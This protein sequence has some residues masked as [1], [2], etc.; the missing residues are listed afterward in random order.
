MKLGISNTSLYNSKGHPITKDGIGHYTQHLIDTLSQRDDISV[1]EISFRGFYKKLATSCALHPHYHQLC[2]KETNHKHLKNIDLLHITDHR[3]PITRVRIPLIA[4]LHDAIPFQHPNWCNYGMRR[5]ILNQIN[6]KIYQRLDHVITDSQSAA[7]DLME[8]CGISEKRISVAHLGI[9][10]RWF[11]RIEET[12]R[13]LALKALG[14]SEPYILVVGTLQVRKNIERILDAFKNLKKT[15]YASTRLIIVGKQHARLTP[16]GLLD[17]I[18][19]TPNA[20]LLSYIAQDTLHALYQNASMLCFPSLIEGF[21]F[22]VLEAFASKIP[23]ITSDGHATK[24]IASHHASLVDPYHTQSIFE[25]MLNILEGHYPADLNKAYHYAK[26]FTWKACMQRHI[27]VYR[28][29][30]P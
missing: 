23:L 3:I 11:E 12:T 6:K 1:Q 24:E 28:N 9:H 26:T 20:H 18:H 29:Y 14:I 4:T 10:E 30:L 17:K 13:S 19:N 25:A 16:K 2:S 7:Q 8:H 15:P 5:K 21:G 22:P 27:E